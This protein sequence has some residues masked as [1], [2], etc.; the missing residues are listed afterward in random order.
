M[1]TTPRPVRSLAFYT[2]TVIT[3]RDGPV[4]MFVEGGGAMGSSILAEK[5]RRSKHEGKKIAVRGISLATL[6]KETVVMGGDEE[7]HLIIKMDV[8]GAEYTILNSAWQTLCR[9]VEENNLHVSLLLELHGRGKI[10]R[11]SDLTAF[12]RDKII[13]KLV[14]C[15]VHI[16]MDSMLLPGWGRVYRSVT[17]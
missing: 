7:S 8:E 5:S 2:E 3:D 9:A 12:H 13:Q 10:G 1:Q 6:L 15:G 17:K 11:N 16:V 4:E 14:K